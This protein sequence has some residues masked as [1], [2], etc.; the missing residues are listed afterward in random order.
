MEIAIEMNFPLVNVFESPYEAWDNRQL[1][2]EEVS[3]RYRETGV[4]EFCANTNLIARVSNHG[5][6]AH[7]MLRRAVDNG[8][9]GH[10]DQHLRNSSDFE[11]MLNL[12]PSVVPESIAAYKNTYPAY[13]LQT[14]SSDIERFG[15]RLREGQ[16]FFHGGFCS[17]EPGET[18][19][20]DRPLSTSFCPQVA[21]RNAEWRG[22]AYEIGE[23]HLFVLKVASPS[24]KAFV[25]PREGDLG[26]EKEALINPGVRLT[27]VRK[28]L[29]RNDYGVCKVDRH[30]NTIEKQ[31]PAYVIEIDVT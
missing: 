6:A 4:L 1:S 29:V 23:V 10:I 27:V 2:P 17:Y 15:G 16:T 21:L 24:V 19:T 8:L 26:N 5:E 20:I 14:V 22:K 30:L 12:M 9:E 7:Y 3:T 28:S 11:E 18:F 31:V 13:D 25:F